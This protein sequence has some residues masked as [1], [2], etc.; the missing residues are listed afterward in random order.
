MGSPSYMSPEQAKGHSHKAD[1]RSDV[2][3]LGVIL[4]ELLTGVLPFRERNLVALLQMIREEEPASIRTLDARIPRDLETICAKCFDKDP[5]KRYQSAGEL[6]NELRRHLGNKPILARPIGFTGKTWR[7]CKRQPVVAGLLAAFVAAMVGGM[8]V[9]TYFAVEAGREARQK[10]EAL[11]QAEEQTELAQEKSRE[12]EK[13]T[14]LAKENAEESRTNAK[15]AERELYFSQI[16]RATGLLEANRHGD[17]FDVLTTIPPEQRQWE[18]N[19]LIRQ[20]EGTP[21]TLRG[22]RSD[23]ASVAFSPDGRS[24]VS[25][26]FNGK[27]K[28]WD[29]ETGKEIRTLRVHEGPVESVAF[30]PDGRRIVSGISCCWNNKN[31]TVKV[32]DAETGQ[33]IHTLRGH[34]ASVNSVAFSPDGRRIVSGSEDKTIKVWDTTTGREMYTLAGHQYDVTCVAFSADG[35]RIGE[36]EL[37][38]YRQGVGCRD[39]QSSTY[40]PPTCKLSHRCRRFQPGR[41]PDRYRELGR[42]N[43]D[44]GHND[45]QGNTHPPRAQSFGQKRRFQPGRTPD[46]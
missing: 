35:R 19:Y 43:Q 28:V 2:F 6:A 17:A 41:A 21:L 16:Y 31:N 20:A 4:Y 40:V 8:G 38:Q 45:G 44:L 39:R 11:E 18:A 30:S 24:I 5:T 14:K 3:S 15:E 34:E 22:H 9:S 36:R 33:E 25:G 42:D 13:Q 10:T 32:W 7:W 37:R 12:A 1:A 46:R 23:V 27:I 26:D 29:A